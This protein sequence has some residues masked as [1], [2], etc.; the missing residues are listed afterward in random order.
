MAV[1]GAERGS[2]LAANEIGVPS[3]REAAI[4]RSGFEGADTSSSRSDA[5]R[6]QLAGFDRPA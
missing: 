5:A 2:C 4:L 1:G 6:L 3:A